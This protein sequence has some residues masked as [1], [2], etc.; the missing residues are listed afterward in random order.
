MCALD[1]QQQRIN[2]FLCCLFECESKEFPFEG[3]CA[4]CC[5]CCLFLLGK[6]EGGR[7]RRRRKGGLTARLNCIVCLRE[8]EQ[9]RCRCRRRLGCDQDDDKTDDDG[10]N[11]G[12]FLAYW[13][14]FTIHTHTQSLITS[15]YFL[16][17]FWLLLLLYVRV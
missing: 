4:Y 7:R 3:T 16:L 5:C 10:G 12:R 14:S 13:H 15:L 8:R 11:G 9:E 2:Q 6:E 17:F 1:K